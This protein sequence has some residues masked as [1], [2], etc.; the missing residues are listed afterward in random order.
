MTFQFQFTANGDV[1]I[2]G[3]SSTTADEY[4]RAGSYVLN[5]DQLIASVINEGSPARV[6][7]RQGD[8]LLTI[9]E[10]LAFRLRRE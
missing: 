10:T 7:L 8:L 1:D 6:R 5:G 2:R 4:Q 9:D 3:K